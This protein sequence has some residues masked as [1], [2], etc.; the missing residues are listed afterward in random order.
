MRKLSIQ[1]IQSIEYDILE[2]FDQFCRVN[3]LTYMLCGGTLLGAVRHQGFIPW[4]DDIDVLMP[5]PDYDKL[6]EFNADYICGK[7]M[8]E[9]KHWKNGKSNYPFIKIVDPDTYVK[10]E[11]INEKA[12]VQQ[13]WI[14]IFPLDGN[15]EDI[16]SANKLYKRV[17][18]YKRVL[19]LKLA[20][21][22]VGST[23]YIKVIKPLVIL[24]LQVIP[25]NYL[26]SKMDSISKTYSYENTNKAG[27]VVWGYGI[28]EYMDKSIF[29]EQTKMLFHKNYYPVPNGYQ[30]YLTRIY[31]D[32][33]VLPSEE[34]RNSHHID[35]YVKGKENG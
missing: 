2:A 28:K 20:K 19:T 5:R 7:K 30:E 16:R 23:W 32:Y 22:G 10:T 35:A 31:G 6:L 1:E 14:D 18:I 33:M 27:G 11:Y 9:I 34:E 26:C 8:Y 29:C 15:P 3:N 25:T 24:L 4:D 12:E 17:K 13:I 21:I